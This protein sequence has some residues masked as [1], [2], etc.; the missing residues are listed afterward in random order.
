MFWQ[1]YVIA[2]VQI[3]FVIALLPSLLGDDKPAETTSFLNAGLL[4]VLVVCEFTLKLYF[5]T[6]T[7]ALT[8]LA[9]AILGVQKLRENK[10]K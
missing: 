8:A 9:W 2:S 4:A 10:E 7:V 5:S 1:D 6:V 3:G